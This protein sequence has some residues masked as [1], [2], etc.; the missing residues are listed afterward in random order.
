M[1]DDSRTDR[2]RG[3]GARRSTTRSFAL[4]SA[5]AAVSCTAMLG[6]PALSATASAQSSLV[7]ELVGSAAV[8]SGFADWAQAPGV[9]VVSGDFNDDG[10]DDLALVGGPGWNTVPVS[11]SRGDGR[12]R[13]TNRQV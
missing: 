10:R 9:K 5:A 2:P 3:G 1:I 8:P 4:Y 12:F 13:V 6:I 11:F 7:S